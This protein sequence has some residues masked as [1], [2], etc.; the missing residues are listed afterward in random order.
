M[1][2]F[3]SR[4]LAV[5]RWPEKSNER[6]F[7]PVAGGSAGHWRGAEVPLAPGR[8]QGWYYQRGGCS[9]MSLQA[10]AQILGLPGVQYGVAA[11]KRVKPME[12]VDA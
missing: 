12:P 1:N 9:E 5:E 10:T 8:A 2:R 11:P 7:D 3:C 6:C 4:G